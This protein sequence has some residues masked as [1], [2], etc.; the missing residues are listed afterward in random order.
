MTL[1]IFKFIVLFIKLLNGHLPVQF[2]N[3]FT[4]KKDIH[5]QNTTQASAIHVI[6]HCTNPMTA[7]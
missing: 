1:I 2:H 4:L 3:L 5:S 6:S 7:K